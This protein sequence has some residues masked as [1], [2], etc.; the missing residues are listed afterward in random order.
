MRHSSECSGVNA[1]HFGASFEDQLKRSSD[2][3]RAFHPARLL[4]GVGLLAILLVFALRHFREELQFAELL[5]EARPAWLILAAVLQLG[6]Y[7]CAAGV[8]WNPLTAMHQRL[9]YRRLISLAVQKLAIDQL[10]PTGGIG[11][12]LIIVRSMRSEGIPTGI[13]TGAVLSDLLTFYGAHAVSLAVA[14]MI[15]RLRGHLPPLVLGLTL[16]FVV[17]ATVVPMTL[18]LVTSEERTIPGW[19]R[20][21]K[22]LAALASVAQAVPPQMLRRASLYLRGVC[23]QLGIWSLD[24][25]TLWV[26]IAAT[27]IHAPA[28]AVFS[29]FVLA[30]ATET[31]SILPAGVG[32]FEATAVFLLHLQGIPLDHALTGTLLLRGFTLWLPLLPGVWLAR[33]TLQANQTSEAAGTFSA[34]AEMNNLKGNGERR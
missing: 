1:Y 23:W 22:P 19:M 32:T 5:R 29:A 33:K 28:S 10:I 20:R 12:R 27:G 30:Q 6:T 24:V 16:G 7:V 14:L 17:L 8:W 18:L 15:L 11:S 9:H 21:L 13:A 31:V 25:A 4:I 3:T 2:A 26:M 34:N